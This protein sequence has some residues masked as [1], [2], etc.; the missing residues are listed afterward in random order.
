MDFAEVRRLFPGTAERVH[1]DA[2]AVSITSTRA[3]EAIQRFLAVITRDAVAAH[4][5]DD[6]PRAPQAA[7]G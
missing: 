6:A 7:A 3:V 5:G 4:Q 1:L 2:A